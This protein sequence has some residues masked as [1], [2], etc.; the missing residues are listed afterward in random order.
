MGEVE[1]R[2]N[3]KTTTTTTSTWLSRAISIPMANTMPMSK[4]NHFGQL[5]IPFADR[6]SSGRG[7]EVAGIVVLFFFL[8]FLL[9][10]A[11]CA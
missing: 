6:G 1:S 5:P 8:I 11:R 7:C 2:Q 4:V 10:G 9:V 3:E